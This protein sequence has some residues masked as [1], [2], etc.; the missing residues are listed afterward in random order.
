MNNDQLI[1]FTCAYTPLP[2]LDAAGYVPYRMLPVG[3]F[4]AQAGGFLHDNLCPHVLRI[5]DRA[6]AGEFP[7]L[8]GVAFINSCDTMRRL[9]DAWMMIWPN[10][11]VAVVDLPTIRNERLI[12][13]FSREIAR[14]GDILTEWSGRDIEPPRLEESIRLYNELFTSLNLLDQKAR[15]GRLPGGRKALQT[16]Y[17]LSVTAPI[18]QTLAE[19]QRLLHE[20]D[21]TSNPSD[22]VP[23]YLVG[24]VLPD[25][26]AMSFIEECGVKV[27]GD[28]LCSSSRLHTEY[29]GRATSVRQDIVMRLAR[30]LMKRPGCARTFDETSPGGI[31][32]EIAERA[33]ACGARGVIAQ[34]MKFCD[35][36]LARLPYI[37]E[38]LQAAG[39]PLL[40][41]MG[42]CTLGSLGQFRTRIE[43]FAEMLR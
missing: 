21:C 9:S 7:P 36:Y 35:P 24:N 6:L 30:G 16:V 3:D 42:D 40:V 13:F 25:P 33:R 43:A 2:L 8:A 12:E 22:S 11:R 31:A 37:Q 4:P 29:V 10:A 39:I 38:E 26:E 20:P 17:N 1:G 27:V 28:D 32:K 23:V 5:L 18:R 34:V 15:S 41:L 19:V 14:L